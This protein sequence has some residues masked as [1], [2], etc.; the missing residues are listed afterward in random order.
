MTLFEWFSTLLGSEPREGASDEEVREA[1]ARVVAIV[2]QVRLANR[3]EARLA[4]AI[5]AT[6][7]YARDLVSALPAPRD[8]TPAAW[9][10][11]PLIRAL[12]ATPDDIGHVF[13]KSHELRAWFDDHFTAT[14]VYAV[15]GSQLMERSVLR[16]AHENGVMRSD[17]PRTAVSFED[18]RIRLFGDA[19]ASLRREIVHRLV[20]QLA[21]EA[22]SRIEATQTRRGEL[23]E[24]RALLRARMQMLDRRGAGMTGLFGSGS[25][26]SPAEAAKLAA[27][28]S[29]NE[30][31]LEQLGPREEAIERQLGTLLEIFSNPSA[32]VQV[33]PRTLRLSQMNLVVEEGCD[34]ECADVRIHVAVVPMQPPQTRAVV[35]VR[36]ARA[37]MPPAGSAHD[38]VA[39]LLL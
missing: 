23:E 33:T 37:D 3:Y 32:L 14:H 10:A 19:D 4:P 16:S 21:L 30:A 7:S 6:L 20:E 22:I 29:R 28:F 38:D 2:P 26:A 1:L 27:E 24:E 35:I 39:H 31:A 18:R 13:G 36:I 34:E 15:L 25:N 5:R 9:A 8:A 11:D 17:V 12:F